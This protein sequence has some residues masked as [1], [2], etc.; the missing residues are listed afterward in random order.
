MLRPQRYPFDQVPYSDT[1]RTGAFGEAAKRL[2][3]EPFLT[4]LAVTFANEGEASVPGEPIREDHPNLHGQRRY[5]CRVPRIIDP[6]Y[7]PVITS[8]IR[9]ATSWTTRR[10]GPG[11]L[12]RRR[13][14]PE[15]LT[16]MLQVFDTSG[17]LWRWRL[18]ANSLVRSWLGR[19]PES[20]LGAQIS[21]L[22][23]QTNLSA[24]VLY[25]IGMGRDIPDGNMTL[26]GSKL[27][28]DWRKLKSGPLFDRLRDTGRRI[29]RELGADFEG[30]P[31]RCLGQVIP[32]AS[33]GPDTAT[34]PTFGKP[35]GLLVAFVR[36]NA[37]V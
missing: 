32:F 4:K 3:L 10:G 23:G 7:G 2:G 11:L 6:G 20:D 13:R 24:G 8:A 1:S 5:T 9:S 33:S 34:G 31:I 15:H 12:P 36:Q 25:M 28:I 17:A 21:E 29:A 22:L 16:W 14:F 37:P 26:R 19:E 27:D 35:G 30:T 18:T